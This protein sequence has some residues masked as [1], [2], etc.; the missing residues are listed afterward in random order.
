MDYLDTF[1]EEARA[2]I[3]SRYYKVMTRIKKGHRSFV[4]S[5]VNAPGNAII[6]ELKPA[7]PSAGDLLKGRKIEELARAYCAGGAVGLS[8]LTEP[9]HFKGSLEHLQKAGVLGLPVLMKDFILDLVQLEACACL[10]GDCVLLILGLFL[11]GYPTVDLGKMI[12]H[13]HRLGLEVLIEVASVDEFN[14]AQKTHAEMIGINSRDLATLKVDLNRT[15]EI[16]NNMARCPTS[17]VQD[18]GHQEGKASPLIWA[19]SGISSSE[20]VR[21]LKSAGAEA[22]L[23][24]TALMRA[25]DPLKKLKELIAA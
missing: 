24:G 19:L 13:A 7:S 4:E 10:G 11:R 20:D 2:R 15:I 14:M 6:A 17:N 16:L 3:E 18:S 1:A 22:F 12:A 9:K 25:K 23:V 8:V 21:I 5:I